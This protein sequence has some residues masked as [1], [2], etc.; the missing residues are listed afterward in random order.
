MRASPLHFSSLELLID[1][2]RSLTLAFGSNRS[3]AGIVSSGPSFI[4][5]TDS[6]GLPRL[7]LEL[8]PWES[9]IAPGMTLSQVRDTVFGLDRPLE[10]K[11]R[12]DGVCVTLLNLTDRIHIRLGVQ[13]VGESVGLLANRTLMENILLPLRYH[14]AS[15][16]ESAR[17]WVEA[18]VR[19]AQA[20][21]DPHL[22]DLADSIDRRPFDT[23]ES[24]RRFAVGLRA[25]S[26]RPR[27]F[28]IEAEDYFSS[29]TL[30]LLLK[31][32]DLWIQRSVAKKN[33]HVVT[34]TRSAAQV[35][36][37]NLVVTQ[38]Q[39]RRMNE[40]LMSTVETK[41]TA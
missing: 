30:S 6:A 5:H 23:S 17:Q 2:G 29:S 24:H 31:S 10:G 14:C 21:S 12:V 3:T 7:R 4:E 35:H 39:V 27:W 8:S 34:A 1:H 25:F 18:V 41:E 33:V 20:L 15:E 13:W 9:L 22:K 38:S 19:D 36:Q 40:L 28:F 37:L 32:F 26:V 11:C 16:V